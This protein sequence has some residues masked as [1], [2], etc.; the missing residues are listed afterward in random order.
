MTITA[1]ITDCEGVPIEEDEGI[2]LR[3][4]L[5]FR[6]PLIASTGPHPHD[7]YCPSW[8]RLTGDNPEGVRRRSHGHPR[9]TPRPG[10]PA[11][12]RNRGQPSPLPAAP[13]AGVRRASAAYHLG[14]PR[15]DHRA[16]VRLRRRRGTHPGADPDERRGQAMPKAK[17]RH[18]QHDR[19]APALAMPG[20]FSASQGSHSGCSQPECD[21]DE[22]PVL[23]PRTARA[24]QSHQPSET[25]DSGG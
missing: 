15:A 13:P 18:P 14:R 20:R 8:C 12:P 25:R 24:A 3:A 19:T 23:A 16:H 4:R 10:R 21:I 5:G 9:D 7:Q 11:G 17:W 1:P 22:G 6:S 2:D